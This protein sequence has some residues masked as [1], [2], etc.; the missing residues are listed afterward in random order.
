VVKCCILYG[1][2]VLQCGDKLWCLGAK[3]ISL[4]L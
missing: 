3:P 1:S 4:A 2:S